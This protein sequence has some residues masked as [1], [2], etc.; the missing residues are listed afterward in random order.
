M[1]AEQQTERFVMNVPIAIYD[2]T[3][4]PEQRG[5]YRIQGGEELRQITL[6]AGGPVLLDLRS[7]QNKGQD[8]LD[9]WAKENVMLLVVVQPEDVGRE[10][11]PREANLVFF[12]TLRDRVETSDYNVA[13]GA[14]VTLTRKP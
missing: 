12:G 8:A 3:L 11:L 4:P 1:R 6:E 14:L 13:D 10:Q 5:Q 2:Q 7:V 9:R